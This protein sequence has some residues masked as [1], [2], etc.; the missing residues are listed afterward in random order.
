M[1]LS[2]KCDYTVVY[3]CG[4]RC[5]AVDAKD[6]TIKGPTALNVPDTP[7]THSGEC[8]RPTFNIRLAKITTR[9]S[10]DSMMHSKQ[11]ATPI[12]TPTE[13]LQEFLLSISCRS[14]RGV[15][16]ARLLMISR[17][18]FMHSFHSFALGLCTGTLKTASSNETM[19]V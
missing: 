10:F 12:R 7:K 19:Q 18:E 6:V 14:V 4:N 11:S 2:K 3:L 5:P 1:P 16:I 9:D 17:S 8:S 15:K 13:S